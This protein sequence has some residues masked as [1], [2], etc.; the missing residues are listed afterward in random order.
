MQT[1]HTAVFYSSVIVNHRDGYL[2][3]TL[4]KIDKTCKCISSE[5]ISLY[6]MMRQPFS[7]PVSVPIPSQ[8][9]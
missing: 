4:L 2:I 6:T 1:L 9:Q 5:G 8:K 7:Q 3:G